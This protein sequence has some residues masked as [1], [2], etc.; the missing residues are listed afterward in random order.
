MTTPKETVAKL[1]GESPPVSFE[2]PMTRRVWEI[3]LMLLGAV[4][5]SWIS[6]SFPQSTVARDTG[7]AALGLLAVLFFVL[8]W[9]F[10]FKSSWMLRFPIAR[11]RAGSPAIPA[12]TTETSGPLVLRAVA[13]GPDVYLNLTHRGS[14]PI[15]VRAEAIEVRPQYEAKLPWP[16]VWR[17]SGQSSQRMQP[18]DT[19]IAL[20]AHQVPDRNPSNPPSLS[21]DSALGEIRIGQL[22]DLVL[23][24]R[25]RSEGRAADYGVSIRFPTGFKSFPQHCDAFAFP[26]DD[27]VVQRLAH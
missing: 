15:D 24:V 12:P 23:R 5:S 26:W 16:I 1:A 8:L 21:L 4:L 18:Q 13:N 25:I 3:A 27:E 22:R 7:A 10:W 2:R 9:E 19:A 17:E 11:K 14:G 6:A 20:I